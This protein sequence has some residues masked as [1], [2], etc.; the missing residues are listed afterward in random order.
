[1]ASNAPFN[2]KYQS[3]VGTHT[4][5]RRVALGK[6]RESE[7]PESC[8]ELYCAEKAAV[9][10]IRSREGTKHEGPTRDIF[11]EQLVQGTLRHGIVGIVD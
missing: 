6:G 5:R 7:K 2:W 9:F 1:M 8:I 11:D 10:L 3:C 4:R